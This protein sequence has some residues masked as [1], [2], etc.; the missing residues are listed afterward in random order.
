MI[1]IDSKKEFE[2]LLIEIEAS[3]KDPT[4]FIRKEVHGKHISGNHCYHV[5]QNYVLENREKFC[6]KPYWHLTLSQLHI[7]LCS[8]QARYI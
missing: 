5:K 3:G 6:T 7:E 2:A 8:D 4:L 1:G